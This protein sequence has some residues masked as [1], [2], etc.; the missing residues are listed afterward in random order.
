LLRAQQLEHEFTAESLAAAVRCTEQALAIDPN[1]AH[2]MAL[3]AHCYG[4]R[5]LQGWTS[6]GVAEAA[7]GVR[8][9]T[10]AVEHGQD[11]CNVLWMAAFAT[12]Y[13]AKDRERARRLVYRS[14]ELNPNS[15]AAITVAGTI[16]AMSNNAARALELLQ[17]A[18]RLSPRDPRGWLT[19]GAMALAH[20]SQ[21]RVEEAITFCDQALLH[22]P[23][24]GG[25]L[26]VLAASFV[27]LN[28]RDKAAEALKRQ[29]K[30]DPH[31]TLTS[32]RARLAFMD[33]RIWNRLAEGLKLAAWPE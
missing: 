3:A 19:S 13:L 25:S 10:D 17:R 26:R 28:Q 16:E 8:L 32:L 21:G 30:I 27:F 23:R 4:T 15:A 14:L 1:Y 5:A 7:E 31:V 12:L 20:F 33:D 11:D 24:F 29:L 9:A 6:D 18:H 2:A 22:N